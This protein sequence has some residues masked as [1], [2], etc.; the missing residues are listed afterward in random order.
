MVFTFKEW[1][2]PRF[3]IKTWSRTD[4]VNGQYFYCLCTYCMREGNGNDCPEHTSFMRMTR[5][6]SISAP[7]FSCPKF[8]EDRKKSGADTSP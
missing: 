5:L 7:V 1:L 4:L 2:E 3:A 8:L 6:L